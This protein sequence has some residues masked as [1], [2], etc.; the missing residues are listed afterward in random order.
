MSGDFASNCPVSWPVKI[1]NLLPEVDLNGIMF[2]YQYGLVYNPQS[3]PFQLK[4]PSGY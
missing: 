3:D 1:A 2:S 4:T